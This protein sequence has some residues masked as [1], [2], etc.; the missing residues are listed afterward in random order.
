MSDSGR[1]SGDCRHGFLKGH[2]DKCELQE[3]S[4]EIVK[5]RDVLIRIRDWGHL[6]CAAIRQ[7]AKVAL[8]GT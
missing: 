8:E 3:R 2:C 5:L 1:S 7:M 6:D 4:H